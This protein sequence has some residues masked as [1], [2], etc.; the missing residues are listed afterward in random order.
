[1][2]WGKGMSTRSESSLEKLPIRNVV[3]ANVRR[4][5]MNRGLSVATLAH[6]SGFKPALVDAV[7][8]GD[9]PPEFGVDE[10]ASIARA[11]DIE[12]SDLVSRDIHQ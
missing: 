1:M 5:R 2:G 9:A 12:D 11:L 10:L 4:F 8:N 6:K 7:E 3:A